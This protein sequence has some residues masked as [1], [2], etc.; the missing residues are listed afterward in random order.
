MSEKMFA[1]F[2][3]NALELLEARGIAC[4]CRR[5]ARLDATAP[6]QDDFLLAVRA[7]IE[8]GQVALYGVFD[9]HGPTGHRCA[10]FARS[11]LPQCIFSDSELF[12]RPRAALRRAFAQ[13]QEELLQQPFNVQVS[14]TTATIALIVDTRTSGGSV[15]CYVA[16]IGDSRAILASRKESDPDAF[17]LSTLTR[18]HRPDDPEEEMRIKRFGG[19]I[20][21]LNNGA[22]VG[23]VFVPGKNHPALPLT[24]SLGAASATECGVLHEP[25]ITSHRLRPGS[26][27]LLVLG[28]DGLF[29]F[30]SRRDVAAPLLE[31]GVSLETLEEI[32]SV[33]RQRWAANSFNQTVDD[34]T[35]VAV[36]LLTH[37]G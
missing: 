24:R 12:S 3:S 8:Q 23:R 26:D 22:G 25:E 31:H 15:R 30:S 32:C 4:L 33:S 18:E 35:I 5:G 16:H 27:L 36:S 21:K 29:E 28:T 17:V 20:R 6:N 1:C 13:T 7:P 34:T 9:G 11:L 2:P 19:E 14:G 37:F 10:A